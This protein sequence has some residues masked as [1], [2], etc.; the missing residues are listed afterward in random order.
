MNIQEVE[1]IEVKLNYG[2][3]VEPLENQ[4]NEQGFTLGEKRDFIEK[5]QHSLYY[6]R[7]HLLTDTQYNSCLKKFHKKVMDSIKPL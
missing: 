4:L 1:T 7:F 5:L 2:V 6:C 3:I